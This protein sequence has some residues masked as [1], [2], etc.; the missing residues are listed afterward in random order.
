[1]RAGESRS[2]VRRQAGF[3][4]VWLLAAVALAGLGLATIGPLWANDA[5]RERE[6]DLAR[7]GDQ[8]AQ[9]IASYYFASP[10][11][12]REY[13]RSLEALLED[14]RGGGVRRHL[15]RLHP[16][17][18]SGGRPWALVQQADGGILGVYSQSTEQPLRRDGFEEG[19]LQ[20][21]PAQRYQDWKFIAKVQP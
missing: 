19:A 20:L 15:R 13:P 14:T 1:M 11:A 9:A 16:D 17:P 4:I 2:A 18:V 8:Y 6:R 12:R 10:I 21:P 7:F 3:G 5:Q